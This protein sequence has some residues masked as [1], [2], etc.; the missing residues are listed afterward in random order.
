M[1]SQ[2]QLSSDG[3]IRGGPKWQL[4]LGS[5]RRLPAGIL[6]Q[7]SVAQIGTLRQFDL[8]VTAPSPLHLQQHRNSGRVWMQHLEFQQKQRRPFQVKYNT[9]IPPSPPLTPKT[10]RLSP[11]QTPLGT[12]RR[13]ALDVEHRLGLAPARHHQAALHP[14]RRHGAPD[15]GAVGRAGRAGDLGARHRGGARRLG[16]ERDDAGDNPRR[17]RRGAGGAAD[18][19][20]RR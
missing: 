7:D 4:R 18:G 17:G 9:Q 1:M 14:A 16:R 20:G 2:G 19:G 3:P 8:W 13:A 11:R 10:D 5:T 6:A 15:R 12:R